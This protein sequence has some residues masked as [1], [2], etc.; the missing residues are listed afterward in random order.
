MIALPLGIG[1]VRAETPWGKVL[2]VSERLTDEEAAA[3]RL[4]AADRV[5][6]GHPI[7]VLKVSDILRRLDAA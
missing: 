7:V 2:M 5:L 1:L 3:G 4:I 6:D